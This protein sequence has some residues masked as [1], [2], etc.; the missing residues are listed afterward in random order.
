MA[1]KR[2]GGQ[3]NKGQ[4]RAATSEAKKF[5]FYKDKVMITGPNVFSEALLQ[6]LI[7]QLLVVVIDLVSLVGFC[8]P[9]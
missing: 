1:S 2:H 6:I 8:V 7:V 9:T 5:G 3:A 4:P